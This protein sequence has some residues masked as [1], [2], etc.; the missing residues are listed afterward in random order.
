MKAKLEEERLLTPTGDGTLHG[1][2]VLQSLVSQCQGS[3]RIVVADSYFVSV[4]ATNALYHL[5]LKFISVVKTEPRH[6]QMSFLSNAVLSGKG[7]RRAVVSTLGTGDLM[8][9]VVWCDRERR[10]FN[11]NYRLYGC[12]YTLCQ[13]EVEADRSQLSYRL[14]QNTWS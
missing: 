4:E 14:H 1:T 8:M 10:Y 3:G 11:C 6:F 5:S 9:A 2:Q 7:D 13:N 12:W